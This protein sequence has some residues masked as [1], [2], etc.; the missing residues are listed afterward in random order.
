MPSVILFDAQGNLYLAETANH[1]VRKVD[2]SG[3][4]TTVAGNGVQGF[5]GD[6]GPATQAQLDSPQG[7]ALDTSGHLYIAD[8]HNSCIRRVDLATGLITTV[9]GGS[10]PGFDG[11]NGPAPG[12]H[13][14]LP[15]ALALDANQNLY[16]A[17][18][19]NHRIRKIT[20]GGIITTVAGNGTQG[21][22]GDNGAATAA[23]IDSPSGLALDSRKN[24]YIADSRNHRIRRVDAITGIIDTIA[25][26]G[27][28]GFSGDDSQA[29]AATLALPRGITIDPSGNLYIADSQNHRIRRIDAVT[30]TI[31]TLAGDGTQ[32]FSGDAGPAAAAS[33]NDP[34]SAALAPTGLLALADTG[35]QRVRQIASD[36]TIRTFA[37]LGASVPGIL[38]LTAPSVIPYGSG[39]LSATLATSTAASGSITFLD[40]FNANTTTLGAANLLANAATRD[41]STLPAGLHALSATYSGDQFHAP[42]HSNT[43]SLTI[44]PLQLAAI[45][46]PATLLYGQPIPTLTGVITGVLP[47]DAARITATFTTTAANLSPVGSY[48]VTALLSGPAAGNYT[49][50]PIPNVAI[51]P[52]PTLITLTTPTTTI[53]AGQSLTLT[54]H[55]ASTTT[56]SPTGT[57]TLTIDAIPQPAITIASTGDAAFTT[58]ALSLGNHTL[59]SQYSGDAN[60]L[61]SSS[62]AS[63]LAV[64]ATASPADFTLA[65][66]GATS[67]T[68]VSGNSAT[69]T[70]TAQPQ[71]T[72]TS[73]ITLAASGLPPFA[74]AA[75]NPSYI[76][77]G[78]AS[79]T[80]NLTIATPRSTAF[81][82]AVAP[83]PIALAILAL[84]L[85]PLTRR[86][87]QPLRILCVAAIL[88]STFLSGCG[89]RIN[90]GARSANGTTAYTITV[91]GT[92]TTPSGTAL[93][94]SASV[95]L[96]L[97]N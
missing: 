51:T 40:T 89:D 88:T 82:P 76:P 57:V 78:S 45:V 92:A 44:S 8:A 31:T 11:D 6:G 14:N 94:H 70:F 1:S 39:H 47:Q 63:S 69:F 64:S 36:A 56:G 22:S 71:G 95:V 50:A 75:F 30:G 34:R 2:T 43:L 21:F 10:T 59:T 60:F 3:N 74:T 12:A 52:A 58:S 33:L 93:Q 41:L 7:L 54:T 24:L 23:S 66:A 91:T 37:G 79:T 46:T 77:P 84:P 72:L 86:R 16:I 55:V 61:P 96:V 48:S 49:I 19:Q 81:Q 53:A 18:T 15:T 17:D 62:A 25:G 5:S 38:T 80:F 29:S 73:P 4:I 13:L 97:Q 87:K 85:I 83:A 27:I 35:N 28:G 9:A 90:T 20:P 65:T 26:T 67:Q 32:S 42:A 68:V